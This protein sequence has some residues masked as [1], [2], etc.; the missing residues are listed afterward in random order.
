ME[1][2]REP[3]PYDPL[4]N[5]PRVDF[6]GEGLH[7]LPRVQYGKD[8]PRQYMECI[9]KDGLTNRPVVVWIHGGGWTDE[10][11]TTTYR[12]ERCMADLAQAGFFIACIEYRLAQHAPFP[13]CV[14]DCQMAIAYLRENADRFGIDPNRI[15]VWGESAGAHIAAMAALNYNNRADAPVQAAVLWYCPADFTLSLAGKENADDSSVA[16]LLGCKPSE[17]PEA[18]RRISPVSYVKPGGTAAFLLMHGDADMLVD[19]DQ[20]V[21]FEKLLED[22]GYDARLITVPG[23]GHGFFVGQEYYDDIVKFLQEKIGKA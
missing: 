16:K 23:Q 17:N 9:Y 4:C 10:Y 21:R 12:P 15:A 18:V 8:H 5:L 22:A 1:Q 2:K 3:S 19:Y 11:L 13:A 20:S 6:V 14:D 7:Y